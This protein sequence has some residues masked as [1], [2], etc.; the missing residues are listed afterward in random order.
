MCC[1]IK[2]N[3]QST[4]GTIG[5]LLRQIDKMQK[6][7]I[8]ANISGSCNTC[9]I[10]PLFNTK[11]I[12]VQTCN[13]VLFA[14]LDTVEG[15]V[16]VNRFRVEE[17]KGDCVIL[18]LLQTVGDETICTN[19]TITCKISCICCVQCFDAITCSLTCMHAA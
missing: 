4:L 17:V 1:E 6:E 8:V 19:Y 16:N 12:S 14:S 3:T 18:R 11:P 13:G 5:D 9:V 10:A 15:T 7:A 2:N